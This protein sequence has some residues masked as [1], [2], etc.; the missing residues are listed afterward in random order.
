M[1]AHAPTGLLRTQRNRTTSDTH[2]DP[3][4]VV[5]VR[6]GVMRSNVLVPPDPDNRH[7]QK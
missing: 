5:T 3:R 1:N 4:T 2:L 6:T 7:P